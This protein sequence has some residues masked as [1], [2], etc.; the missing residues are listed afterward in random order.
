MKKLL[1]LALTAVVIGGCDIRTEETKN[2]TYKKSKDIFETARENR[3][4]QRLEYEKWQGYELKVIDGCEYLIKEFYGYKKASISIVHKGNC[5]FCTER[6]KQELKELIKEV[7]NE[8]K[9]LQESH[10]Q[11]WSLQALLSEDKSKDSR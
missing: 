8:T 1:L 9:E 4:K 2:G 11:S 5:R 10:S 6:R 7:T 3:E